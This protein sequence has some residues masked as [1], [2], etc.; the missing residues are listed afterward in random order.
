MNWTF[1]VFAKIHLPNKNDILIVDL[2]F[3]DLKQRKMTGQNPESLCSTVLKFSGWKVGHLHRKMNKIIS[4]FLTAASKVE[5]E[6][7]HLISHPKKKHVTW[8][9]QYFRGCHGNTTCD[10]CATERFISP[11]VDNMHLLMIRKMRPI[12][13]DRTII[14]ITTKSQ[15]YLR[16]EVMLDAFD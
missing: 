15:M 14:P 2:K 12:T 1:F 3:G 5:P 10:K 16:K 4:V 6:L 11:F 9:S 8:N 13:K 7:Y